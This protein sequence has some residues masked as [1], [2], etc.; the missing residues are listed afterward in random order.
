MF[1]MKHN[2]LGLRRVGYGFSWN[3]ERGDVYV[4][5]FPYWF[6]LFYTGILNLFQDASDDRI[7]CEA[8]A[9]VNKNCFSMFFQ[10]YYRVNSYG[11][12]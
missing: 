2:P 5:Y 1:N 6:S 7:I 11:K 9:L 4:H 3:I 8:F 12:N 10:L